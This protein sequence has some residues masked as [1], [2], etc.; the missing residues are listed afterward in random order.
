MEKVQVDCY[1]NNLNRLIFLIFLY[2][3]EL[4]YS[5]YIFFKILK[6]LKKYINIIFPQRKIIPALNWNKIFRS[7]L[8]WRE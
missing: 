8:K 6:I 1:L 7:N 2:K 3:N 5:Q 4:L